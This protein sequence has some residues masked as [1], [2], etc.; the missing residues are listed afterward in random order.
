MADLAD[1][2]SHSLVVSYCSYEQSSNSC[3]HIQAAKTI[4]E[5]FDSLIG[6][7]PIQELSGIS[8]YV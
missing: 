6:I 3:L 8:V 1:S 4:L 5:E 7:T 2:L